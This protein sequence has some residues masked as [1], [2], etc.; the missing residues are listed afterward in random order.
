MLAPNKQNLILLKNK[1]KSM[2][3]GF[4][5]L[6][7]KRAGLI[8]TFLNFAKEGK[9]LE[10]HLNKDM[11]IS[12][13]NFKSSTVFTNNEDLSDT[14]SSVPS[15]K[16]R[17]GKKRISGVYIDKLSLTAVSPERKDLKNSIQFS[18]DQFT[19]QFPKLI[20][21]SQLKINVN[22]LAEEILKTNRQISNLERKIEDTHA[23][24]KYIKSALMERENLEKSILMK[25]FA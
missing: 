13:N 5:L 25:L 12:L 3:N 19:S 14:L 17:T 1:V 23:Q 10:S 9:V 2:N 24:I 8:I 16:L 4:K 6:K 20:E 21:L 15:T 7:E 18:F 22:K 11:D